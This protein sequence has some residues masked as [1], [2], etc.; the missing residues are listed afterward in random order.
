VLF[1]IFALSEP[2]PMPDRQ[3][4]IFAAVLAAGS[5]SR[6]GSTKQ[7]VELDGL[8][9]VQRAMATAAEV[10]ENR[11]VTVIGHDWATVLKL[12]NSQSGFAVF[13]ED[14][15]N[16][17]GTSIAAA[18]RACQRCADAMLVVLADQPLITAGHL[19]SLI[20]RWSGADDEI[21]ATAFAGTHGPPVLFPS[22]AFSALHS[23]MGDQGARALLRDRR[24]S[25][26][27]VH[28]EAAAVDIDTP[29]DLTAVVNRA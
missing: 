1:F 3:H 24:F 19:Q 10:C 21:V 8:S 12:V 4:T 9:L 13:N 16:G 20:D 27:T 5:S 22:G 17:L 11:V 29:A 2:R 23:L 15:E 26:K 28:F 18:A 25:L 14:Y 6:F 7:A